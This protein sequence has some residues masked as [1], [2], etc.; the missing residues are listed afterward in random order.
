LN[1]IDLSDKKQMK[2]KFKLVITGNPGVGKHTA[3]NRV[4]RRISGANIIDINRVAIDNDAILQRDD[5]YGIDIDVK[6]V[7]KLIACE[8]KKNSGA[9]LIVGHLAPYVLSPAKI[10]MVVVLRRSPY[11]LISVFKKRNYALEKAREN[12]ASEILGISLYDAVKTFSKS[13]VA[14]LDTTGKTAWQTSDEI[15]SLL[16]KKSRPVVGLTDW[17][18]VVH[19][20]G[21][22]HRFLE[23]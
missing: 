16:Q 9:L 4:A 6:K 15:I 3:A 5:E 11:E 7:T 21:D 17:V 13:K 2:N 18:S 19:N 22:I 8:I 20:K 14:E 10:D 23:Y 1:I 12:I